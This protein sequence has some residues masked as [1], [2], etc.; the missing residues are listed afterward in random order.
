MNKLSHLVISII[1]CRPACSCFILRGVVDVGVLHLHPVIRIGVVAIGLVFIVF[2]HICC[3]PPCHSL[4]EDENEDGEENEKSSKG[5][6][7]N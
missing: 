5:K 4:F 3:S 7:K 6:G 2:D 1:V